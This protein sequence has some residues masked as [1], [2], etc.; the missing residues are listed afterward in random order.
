MLI[1]YAWMSTSDQNLDRQMSVLTAV[2]CSKIFADK[3]PGK[4]A[5]RPQL[6]LL[7]DY[8]R[9]G[10]AL[11]VAS[12]DKL[13]R[14]LQDLISLVVGL[15][16]SGVGFKALHENLDTTTPGGRLIFDVFAALADF[17]REL[18]VDGTREGL[19]AARARGHVGGRP[20]VMS[21]EKIAA[22]RAL[23]PEESVA[24]IARQI[25]VSRSTLYA[26]MGAV[27]AGT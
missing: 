14:S 2:G 19:A 22:A 15:R 10:D 23:L 13:A 26:H 21:A 27:T 17:L 3:E 7:L 25:G 5:E 16:R 24:A 20:T 12:L 18:I 1:G 6:L 9:P 4:N 11:V 8:A